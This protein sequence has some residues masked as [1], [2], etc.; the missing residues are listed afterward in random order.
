MPAKSIDPKTYSP[1]VKTTIRRLQKEKIGFD[2]KT[3]YQI[4]VDDLNFYPGRGTI[5]RDGDTKALREIGL[6]AFVALIT[7][8]QKASKNFFIIPPYLNL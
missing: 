8:Q 5:F 1:T 6:D 7:K 2:V 4:K 3:P